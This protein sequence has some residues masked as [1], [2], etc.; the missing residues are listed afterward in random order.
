LAWPNLLAGKMI[1][2]ELKKVLTVEE[3]A[4]AAEPFL[5][6]EHLYQS[7]RQILMETMGGKGA[8]QKLVGLLEEVM[9]P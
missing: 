4:A 5:S 6:D 9:N 8:A 1:V 7:T 3:I 2:P